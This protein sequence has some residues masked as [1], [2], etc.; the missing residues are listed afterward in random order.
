MMSN[1]RVL[2]QALFSS[3]SYSF[4]I[5]L[6]RSNAANIFRANKIKITAANFLRRT[7]I[8]EN[9]VGDRNKQMCVGMCGWNRACEVGVPYGMQGCTEKLD[10]IKFTLGY[11]YTIS[12]LK[13]KV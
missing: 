12:N 9:S 3:T 7:P 2:S 11:L 8:N 10:H 1:F 4:T 6:I 5:Y 13:I